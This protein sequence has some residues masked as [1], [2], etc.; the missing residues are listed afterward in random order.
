M[1]KIPV[2]STIVGSYK[3]LF[4]NIVSIIGTL[5]FPTVLLLALAAALVHQVV[6]HDW[7]QGKFSPDQIEG[8]VRAHL[9]TIVF[10]ALGLIVASLLIRAMVTVGILRHAI[11]EKTST[12]F[13][14]FSLG[15]RVWRMVGALL[16]VFFVYVLLEVGGMIVVGAV[17]L[18]LAQIPTVPN[19]V[20]HLIRTVFALAV[21]LVILY[22][23]LRLF[24][25]LPAI[26]VAEN[27]VGVARAWE[28][29][30]GNV[31]RMI[32]VFLVAVIP[33]YV[34]AVGACVAVL[35]TS[36]IFANL[37]HHPH[38]PEAAM[39]FFK[40]IWPVV[41]VLAAICIV[42]AIALTGLILGAMGHA[43][44]AVTAPEEAKS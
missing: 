29:G 39:A 40:A 31:W 8:A 32:G 18:V 16:V 21:A 44:K 36:G 6:P 38:G 13:I 10:G 43:Y 14:Y 24:F 9:P 11:G 5:W 4:S 23:M 33:A 35:F 17:K 22:V 2:G 27:K 25:F 1:K 19:A 3:F 28:M 20:A 42:L 12:T 41:P 34:V 30:K 26:V 37:S 15:A 7:C